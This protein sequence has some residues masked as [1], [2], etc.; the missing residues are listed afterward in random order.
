MWKKWAIAALAY[1]LIIMIGYG[2]YES[3]VGPDRNPVEQMEMEK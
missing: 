1:L 3:I 2:V